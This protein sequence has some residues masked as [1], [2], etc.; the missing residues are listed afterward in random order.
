[1]HRSGCEE[2]GGSSYSI[3]AKASLFVGEWEQ[4][5]ACLEQVLILPDY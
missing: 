2:A 5:L 1:M 4:P 3:S